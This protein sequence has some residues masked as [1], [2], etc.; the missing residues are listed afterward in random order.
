MMQCPCGSDQKLDGC[1]GPIINGTPAP[2]AEALLRS[3]YTAFVQ[4]NFSY[5]AD[6]LSPEIRDDF[7]QIDTEKTVGGAKWLGLEVHAITDGGENDES[8]AI[9]F[10]A[11][12]QLGGKQHIHHELAMFRR[13]QGRWL[14]VGEQ[15]NPKGAPVQINKVGRNEPCPCGSGKKYKQCHG[16]LV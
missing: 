3:R 15:V 16:K 14:C 4:G 6:T 13:D 10:T 7:D 5:L 9:E 1:C 11:R 2:T 12:F 8:G